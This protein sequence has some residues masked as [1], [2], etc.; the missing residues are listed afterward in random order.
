[1]GAIASARLRRRLSTEGIVRS[2]SVAF[3]LAVALAGFSQVLLLTMLALFVAGGSWVLALS[4]FNVSVQLSTPRWVVAR[5]LSLYQMF[6]FA[7][8]AGGSWL[9]GELAEAHSLSMSLWFAA[10]V[11]LFC[12]LLG[13]WL[14][15]QQA[16]ALN[17]DPLRSWQ[18]PQ[19]AVPV[20]LRTG[21]VVVTIEYRIREADVIEFLR[22]MGERRRIRR[23]DGARNWMLLRDLADPEIWIERYNVP[24]WMDYI[25][26]NNR[27]TQEDADIPARLRALHQGPGLPTVRRMIERQTDSLPIA[28]DSA[29]HDLAEPYTDP[30]RAT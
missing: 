9:W 16:E 30:H 7:G 18:A 4:T 23:R 10:G 13:R 24:T 15:L 20:E 8:M 19:T 14:P 25:R 22:A 2:A 11:L 17:L 27:L 28:S 21:P 3:A 6:A 29:A 26:H 12:A 1:L 5:A